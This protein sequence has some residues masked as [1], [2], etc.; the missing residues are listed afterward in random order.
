MIQ[1]SVPYIV[2]KEMFAGSRQKRTKGVNLLLMD[3]GSDLEFR[4]V[5][6]SRCT[7]RHKSSIIKVQTELLGKLIV[8]LCCLQ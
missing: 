4:A 1:D 5:I 3:I 2:D 7:Q 6:M 8:G